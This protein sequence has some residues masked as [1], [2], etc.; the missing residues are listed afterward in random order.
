MDFVVHPSPP[1]TAS[2]NTNEETS[3]THQGRSARSQ[4]NATVA[5][6]TSGARPRS[7]LPSGNSGA[8]SYL[9]QRLS[10]QP[11]S[12]AVVSG[13]DSIPSSIIGRK[14]RDMTVIDTV[15]GPRGWYI[16]HCSHHLA[17]GEEVLFEVSLVAPIHLTVCKAYLLAHS[18]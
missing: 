13:R 3:R 12:A 1:S 5:S 6:F 16:E 8:P 14:S 10:I 17:N 18:L 4:S 7:R 9:S 15:T 2:V 11:S